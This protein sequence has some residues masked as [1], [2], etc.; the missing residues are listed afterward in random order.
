MRRLPIAF[1]AI[2]L[3]NPTLAAAQDTPAGQPRDFSQR[4]RIVGGRTAVLANWPGQAALRLVDSEGPKYVCG[5]ALVTQKTVLT[6]AHC[7]A[8]Y[9]KHDGVWHDPT[10][11]TAEIVLETDNLRQVTPDNVHRIAD[12]VIH[13]DYRSA[14]KGNDIAII[15]LSEPANSDLARLSLSPA[16]DPTQAWVTPV[17]VAG[18]GVDSEGAALKE[19]PSRDGSAFFAGVS[20]LQEAVVPLTDHAACRDVYGSASIGDEQ[21][22]AGFVEGGKDS[23]QGDS[24]GPLVAF[25]RDGYPYQVGVVSWGA[26]CARESAYGVY[27]RVSAYADW[28]RQNAQAVRAVSLDAVGAP[29]SPASELVDS[30]FLLLNDELPGARGKADVAIEGGTKLRLGDNAVFTLSSDIEGR[31]L[32]IDINA[33]GNVAQ[34]YPNPFSQGATVAA[35]GTFSVPDNSGYRFP[36]QEPTGRG[37]LVALVVPDSFNMKALNKAKRSKGFGVAANLSYMQNL[38][39]LIQIARGTEKGFGV[40]AT[41]STSDPAADKADC[42]ALADLDYEI[43]RQ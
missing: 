38:I 37:K 1:L 3:T 24:G 41:G 17:M 40:V 39:N 22:C 16:S 23:C 34:L 19:F 9:Y 28:L 8:S 21:I 18:F 32:I 30:T 11:R 31:V 14:S 29:T 4:D 5:G 10:G 35:G 12:I 2:F 25:D 7:V 26:G 20:H 13:E 15:Q 42:W 27:T 33:D 6:A 43:T 36:A